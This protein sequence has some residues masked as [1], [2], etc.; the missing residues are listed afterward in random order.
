MSKHTPGP[1]TH[2]PE[3]RDICGPDDESVA[4][5]ATWRPE[6]EEVANARLIAAAPEL[7]AALETLLTAVDDAVDVEAQ[8]SWQGAATDAEIAIAKAKGEA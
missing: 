6:S 5:A 4:S 2:G 8:A 7:L 1:W 3:S